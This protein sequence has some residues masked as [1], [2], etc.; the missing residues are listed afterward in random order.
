MA[1]LEISAE[2]ALATLRAFAYATAQ[3]LDDVARQVV[4]RQLRFPVSNR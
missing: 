3:P 2:S 4:S 1:Q